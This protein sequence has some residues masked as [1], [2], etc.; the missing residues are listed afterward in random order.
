MTEGNIQEALFLSE[1]RANRPTTKNLTARTRSRINGNKTK[2]QFLIDQVTTHLGR[3]ET[4][5]YKLPWGVK[6]STQKAF[7]TLESL[8]CWVCRKI[9]TL[10]RNRRTKREAVQQCIFHSKETCCTDF[11]V[12]NRLYRSKDLKELGKLKPDNH[13][14]V[15]SKFHIQVQKLSSCSFCKQLKFLSSIA[16]SHFAV[17]TLWLAS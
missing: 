4:V 6:I 12:K 3:K 14:H 5:V 15:I 11:H 16:R 7:S 17:I 1:G 9:F 13:Q 8:P 10:E 2:Q